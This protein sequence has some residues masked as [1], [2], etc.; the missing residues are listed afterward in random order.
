M[1][2]LD[3]LP[4]APGFCGD[5]KVVE[6]HALRDAL[7]LAEGGVDA[8]M[9]ENFGDVPFGAGRAGAETVAAMTRCAWAVGQA[10]ALPLGIN[11]L[12]NDVRSALAIARAVEASFVRVNVHIGL[13]LTDQG[14]I[15]GEAFDTLRYRA[16]IGAR[17][18]KIWADLDVKHSQPLVK[19]DP[20]IEVE[21]LVHRGLADAIIVTG[22]TTGR[23]PQKEA[24]SGLRD[25]AGVPVVVG[26]GLTA[27][28][29]AEFSA[30]LDVCIVGT[31]FKEEGILSRPVDADRVRAFMKA[32]GRA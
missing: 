6:D 28:T 24:L 13:R 32:A 16:A 7:A 14:M 25:R 18:V 2:H 11:V 29:M 1:V 4:G 17:D 12:R 5:L 20:L 23:P 22:S 15:Q 8:I 21:E 10:A 30:L 27:D 26:S 3:A 19:A 31:H 9:I